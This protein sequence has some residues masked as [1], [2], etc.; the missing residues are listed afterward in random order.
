M[1]CSPAGAADG[2]EPPNAGP[3]G[4][5]HPLETYVRERVLHCL[6][7]LALHHFDHVV[8]R[9][10]ARGPAF[11]S[12]HV[13]LLVQVAKERSLLMKLLVHLTDILNELRKAEEG[14]GGGPD[15]PDAA[16]PAGPLGN[17]RAIRAATAPCSHSLGRTPPR[18][19]GG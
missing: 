3:G 13:E 10:L 16:V 9:L 18:S 1:A 19:T 6:K 12:C 8:D 15:L 14:R 2:G 11:D 5:D 4:H 17:S 7:T